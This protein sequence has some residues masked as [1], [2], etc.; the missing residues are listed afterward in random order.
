MEDL[1]WTANS[2]LS[3]PVMISF[4]PILSYLPQKIV[5]FIVDY[6]PDWI[7][8]LQLPA[9]DGLHRQ[10]RSEHFQQALQRLENMPDVD[11]PVQLFSSVDIGHRQWLGR[12]TVHAVPFKKPKTRM[13]CD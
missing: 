1:A 8:D 9:S 3:E 6:H 2:G 12:Q 10:L 11:M 4:F 7:S 13:V 5:H